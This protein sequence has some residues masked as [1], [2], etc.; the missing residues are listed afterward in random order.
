VYLHLDAA[1]DRQV[2]ALDIGHIG[3]GAPLDDLHG[4][5]VA[6][7]VR[8]ALDVEDVCG[9]RVHVG[10]RVGEDPDRFGG[11]PVLE[12]PGLVPEAVRAK[13]GDVG[14]DP[15]EEFVCCAHAPQCFTP[16]A[17]TWLSR[18]TR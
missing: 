4:L 16:R 3:V 12:P 15:V 7:V 5:Y 10:V 17:G 11:G 9:H 13:F 14:H 2:H 1:D 18:P 6:H 8:V